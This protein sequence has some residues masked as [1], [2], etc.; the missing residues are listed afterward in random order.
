M[1]KFFAPSPQIMEPSSPQQRRTKYPWHDVPLGKSFVIPDTALSWPSLLTLMR[2][3]SVRLAKAFKAHHHKDQGI[4]EI[5][6]T[7]QLAPS[8]EIKVSPAV[9]I[10]PANVVLD[11]IKK[12]ET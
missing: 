6:Y 3:T 7:G 12:I 11:E 2:R 1:D 4:Y 9:S 5:M 10:A 8:D